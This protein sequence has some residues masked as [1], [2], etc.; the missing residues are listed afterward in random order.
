V[1]P[2]PPTATPPVWRD[3]VHLMGIPISVAL[4]GREAG[5]TAGQD[6]WGRVVA[7]LRA[8]DEVFSTYRADSIISR[9]DRGE[10]SLAELDDLDVRVAA[11]VREVVAL[12]EAARQETAGAFDIRRP[13]PDGSVHLDP[14]GVVKGWAVQRASRHLRELDDTDFCLSAGGDLVAEVAEPAR[15]AWNIGIENPASPSEIVA[16]VALRTGAVATSGS[17]HRGAHILD[18]RTGR[19]PE[20]VAQVTVVADDLTWADVDATAAFA[21]GPDALTWLAGRAGRSGLV[22]WTDGT[23]ETVHSGSGIFN[24]T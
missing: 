20:R 8:A 15:P 7:D 22:V 23:C 6:A 10:L 17:A 11:E 1:S 19:V 24:L 5:T 9:L 21:L 3:V 16:T 18:A 14:S 4:R 12:G 2:A 13:H